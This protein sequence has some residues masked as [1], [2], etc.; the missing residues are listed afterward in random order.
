MSG[1]PQQTAESVLGTIDYCEE[2]L[3]RFGKDGRL[4]PF[5]SPLAPF[6]DPGSRGFE[7]PEEHG[8]RLFA[9]TLE[10]HRR[11]LVAPSWKYVLNYETR[12]MDRHQ[13]VDATYAA[14][15]RLN[16]IKAEY[17]LIP[18]R[19]AEATEQRI[20]WAMALLAEIDELMATASPDVFAREMARLR[21]AIEQAN[22]STV[23]DKR[24]LNVD[25]T[26]PRLNYGTVAHLLLKD[27]VQTLGR[28]LAAPLRPRLAE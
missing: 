7:N 10:E 21:P 3:K 11:L 5:I 4:S 28:K 23:C 20:E 9:R 27:T 26:G 18:A 22:M 13:L 1:L 17:G 14:G 12:W 24:E 2:L 15:K 16:R 6:L 25:M 19:Q 8:Y